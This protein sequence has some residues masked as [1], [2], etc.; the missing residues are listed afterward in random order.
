MADFQAVGSFENLSLERRGC[1]FMITMKLGAENRLTAKFCQELIHAFNT[2]RQTLG[3]NSEGAVI[4]RGNNAKFFCTGLDLDEA[5]QNPHATTEGFYPLLHTILD[6]PFPTIALLTGHT[7]GG[8][9]PVAF[10]HDYRVMN[11]KRGF[12]SMPPVDL[13]MYFPGVGVLPRLKLRPQIARK[14]LLEGHRFT[15]EEALRDGLVDFIAQ[16]DDMLAVAFE[17]AAKWAPKAKAGVYALLRSELNGEM[18]RA[19]QQISHV[20]GRSTFLPGKTKL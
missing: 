8:G 6:F 11:S 12:I 17:L 7:F 19:V 10:A 5:E 20:Y 1:V 14:V 15:G 13:G 2:V 9:C 3:T 4:T 16:P 18:T